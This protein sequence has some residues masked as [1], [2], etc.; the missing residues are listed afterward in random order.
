[1][2]NAKKEFIVDFTNEFTR[3]D[4]VEMID[5]AL[6]TICMLPDDDDWNMYKADIINPLT[7]LHQF[8]YY[9][10]RDEERKRWD[11]ECLARYIK[12]YGEG[13]GKRK[14]NENFPG[15]AVQ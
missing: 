14:Y 5:H 4:L 12:M 15:K 10:K 8:F 3:E 6:A 7:L 9:Q 11:A 2:A 1:M 13:E